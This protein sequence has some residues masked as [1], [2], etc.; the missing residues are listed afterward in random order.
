[1]FH[2]ALAIADDVG[3]MLVVVLFYTEAIRVQPLLLG[4]AALAAIAI[5]VL[6]TPDR[7]MYT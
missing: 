7:L 2:T 1:V 3:A 5:V 4:A 6:R